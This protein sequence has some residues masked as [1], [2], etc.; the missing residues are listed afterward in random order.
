MKKSV[1]VFGAVIISIILTVLAACSSDTST[2]DSESG[3]G[4]D[5]P[6]KSITLIAPST[7]GGGTD[8][9]ARALA[10]EAEKLLGQAIGVV[11]KPGGSGS[12]GMTEGANAKPDGYTVTM[13]FVELTMYEHLGLSPLTPKQIKPVALINF[14]PAALT[15][16]AD[17]PYDTLDEFIAYVKE[18]PGEVKI[19]NSGTGSIWHIAAANLETNA[20]IKVNH[21]PFEGAAQAATALVGGHVDAVT[22]SPAEVKAQL[23]AG[24]V[25]TLAVM[26]DN[27]SDII[28][29]VPT[30]KEAGLD[31]APIGTWR[32]L[33]VPKDTPDEVVA[34]LEDAFLKAAEKESF[35]KFMSNSGLGIQLKSSSE[36]RTFMD[37]NY[38]FYGE[39]ISGLDLN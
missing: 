34:V 3:K 9:T 10:A 5:F 13:A 11:N 17:A 25:K 6:K 31:V 29:D 8:A 12:I 24:N 18:H 23:D 2:T 30:F 26:S 7:A 1:K 35:T 14:D 39:I 32:G 16:P 22:V 27:R 20:D 4:S 36:F 15:V 21:V 28:P 19:G 38:E 33:T 37:E